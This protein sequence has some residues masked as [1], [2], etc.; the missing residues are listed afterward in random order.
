VLRALCLRHRWNRRHQHS[1][2]ASRQRQAL[3]Q[4]TNP[5]VS[6]LKIYIRVVML[7]ALQDN[8]Q[9]QTF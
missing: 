3:S 5:H 8:R 1:H 9:D 4:L 7:K 6:P 2:Q